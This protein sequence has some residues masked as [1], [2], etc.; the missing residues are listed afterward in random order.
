VHEPGGDACLGGD[1]RDAHVVDPLAGDESHGGVEQPL[2]SLWCVLRADARNPNP[3]D[4]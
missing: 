3:T 2:A 4:P 1:A